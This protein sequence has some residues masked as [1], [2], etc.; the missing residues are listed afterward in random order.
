MGLTASLFSDIFTFDLL[1]IILAFTISSLV[2]WYSMPRIVNLLLIRNITDKPDSRKLHNGSI[3]T[4][5][6][7]GIYGGFTIGLFMTFNGS[8]QVLQWVNIAMLFL[9]FTGIRDDLVNIRPH[10]KLIVEILSAFIII[11]FTDLQITNFHGFLGLEIIPVWL[12]YIT[13]IILVVFVINSFNLIDG[14]DGLA[15]SIGII[16]S[17]TLGILFWYAGDIGFAI[18][19]A[20]LAGSL[21]TFFCY[22]I[23]EGKNKIF[24]GDTGSLLIGFVLSVLIIRFNEQNALLFSPLQLRSSPAISMAILCVPL[25]DTLRVF[26]VRIFHRQNPFKADNRHIHHLLLRAGCSH[27]RATFII[28]IFNIFIIVMAFILDF[29]GIIMLTTLILIF[30]AAFTSI[31]INLPARIPGKNKEKDF[32]LSLALRRKIAQ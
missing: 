4:L 20:A 17:F 1:R 8:L 24:M 19:S 11:Y 22:N 30:S 26:V 9:V 7:I 14:I 23:S 27:L 25:F 10:K 29:L 15:S 21:F 3:P 5:G 6:G 28:S 12:S 13:T 18:M 32:S 2:S 16:A 31:I